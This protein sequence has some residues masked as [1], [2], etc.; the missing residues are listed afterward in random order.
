MLRDITTRCTTT[1]HISSW[2]NI[3]MGHALIN[4]KDTIYYNEDSFI[5]TVTS[6]ITVNHLNRDLFIDSSFESLWSI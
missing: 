3:Y 1:M 6:E 4:F 5:V 2:S